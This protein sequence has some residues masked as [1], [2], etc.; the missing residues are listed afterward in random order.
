MACD[1]CLNFL[2]SKAHPSAFSLLIKSG[3]LSRS[4]LLLLL[5]FPWS[6]SAWRDSTV[7][8]YAIGG[9]GRGIGSCSFKGTIIWMGGG[10]FT[11]TNLG[12][13]IGGGDWIYGWPMVLWIL[14]GSVVTATSGVFYVSVS[15]IMLSCFYWPYL[16]M[17]LS[18]FSDN[19]ISSIGAAGTTTG[20]GFGGGGMTFG[21]SSTTGN[22]LGIEG[23]GGSAFFSSTYYYNYYTGAGGTPF[24]SLIFSQSPFSHSSNCFS[25]S[26]SSLITLRAYFS[27]A[28][29]MPATSSYLS[30]PSRFL[31]I[32][33]T[34]HSCPTA[35]SCWNFLFFVLLQRLAAFFTV[36]STS[37]RHSSTLSLVSRAGAPPEETYWSSAKADAPAPGL[38]RCAT[39]REPS[40]T[41]SSPS[42]SWERKSCSFS[43]VNLSIETNY[44][45]V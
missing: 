20:C 23:G 22:G 15:L 6:D 13:T 30:S 35:K 44:S 33:K 32:L 37:L 7:Q 40:S 12:S 8:S 31:S 29:L 39:S 19:F 25:I 4:L 42:G 1:Q 36:V 43:G 14:G 27:L 10:S 3:L 21:C 26:P 45:R 28:S 41:L 11:S 16:F 18:S 2:A 24:I 34:S 38:F 9:G 17:A 5:S